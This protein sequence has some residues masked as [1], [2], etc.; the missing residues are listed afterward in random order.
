MK[1]NL[2]VN[3]L[4]IGL[5]LVLIFG[6][7]PFPRLGV[8]GAALA[9][10]LAWVLGAAWVLLS[11]LRRHGFRL[12]GGGGLLRRIVG[13]G[14]PI[15]IQRVLGVGGFAVFTAMLAR[16]GEAELAA[17]Q[18][19]LRILSMSFLPGY[20]ISEAACLLTGQYTGAGDH[21]AV[22]RSLRSALQLAVGI[23]G[24]FGLVFWLTPELLVTCFTR[25][26]RVV[27][28]GCELLWVAAVFQ[29]FDAVAMVT[30]GALNGT[31]DT[32]FTMMLGILST[33][34][35]LVP[36]AWLCGVVAGLGATGAWIGLT[37]EILAYAVVASLRFH[38]GGWQGKAVVLQAG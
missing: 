15:G 2:L 20:G 6:L 23:M 18:I 14:L 26:P 22:R 12:K 24:G 37:V 29:V 17:H 19:A 32:R 36:A 4:N 9:T 3:G 33:W 27:T 34:L 11:T 5:D 1:V 35:V 8:A 7:G 28:L 25:D 38:R 10:V 30:A 21:L 13:L 31:G 16:M